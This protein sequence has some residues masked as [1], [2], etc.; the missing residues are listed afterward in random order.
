VALSPDDL[1]QIRSVVRAELQQ[2]LPRISRSPGAA[3]LLF[4]ILIG[5]FLGV[6]AI[7]VLVIGGFT[8][9]HLLHH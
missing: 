3:A 9:Y 2:E 1:E 4:R 8:V 5:T 6:L 7:H